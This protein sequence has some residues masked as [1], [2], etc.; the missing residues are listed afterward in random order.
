M[1]SDTIQ[2]ALPQA[3]GRFV[4]RIDP[5][6]HAALR[7]GA[8]EV[9]LSLNEY[10][11]RK[12]ALPAGSIAGPGAD[13][14]ARAAGQVGDALL[15]VL[16]FGSW[17]RRELSHG[18]DVD[19][20]IIV[21]DGFHIDRGA[22]RAWDD[23]PLSWEG[24]PVEPHFVHLPERESRLSGLWAEVAIDGVVLFERGS[25]VSKRLAEVRQKIVS[26]DIVRRLS[27]GQS[28]WVE[29]GRDAKR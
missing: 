8:R 6:L 3:S 23:A 12:L 24:H 17:A 29:V 27:H 11:A 7:A 18:S 16:A 20:L 13:V 22:Y 14:V 5:G 1:V 26:G 15:G 25:I 9:G 2:N 19:L 21:E 28:Y 10:C 4:L